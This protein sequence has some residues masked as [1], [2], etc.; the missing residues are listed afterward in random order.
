MAELVK[1]VNEGVE[2]ASILT[3]ACP[4]AAAPNGPYASSNPAINP[5]AGLGVILPT[6]AGVPSI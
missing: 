6:S 1:L 3:S 2:P 4:T 5:L